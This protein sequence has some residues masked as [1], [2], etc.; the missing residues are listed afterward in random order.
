MSI[1][2]PRDFRT[3]GFFGSSRAKLN[4][5]MYSNVVQAAVQ[6]A[7]SGWR[8][9]NLGDTGYMHAVVKGAR[10]GAELIASDEETYE[11]LTQFVDYRPLLVDQSLDERLH[12]LRQMDAFIICPGGYGTLLE[13]SMLI[14]LFNRE[15]L[16]WAPIYLVGTGWRI[17][18]QVYNDYGFK[19]GYLSQDNAKYINFVD[20]P[21]EASVQLCR[22]K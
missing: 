20:Y 14:N 19:E 9:A 8:V 13:F 6:L 7:Q 11:R 5:F 21:L 17:P 22:I 16:D 18:I 15:E 12:L 1:I 4:T 3:V 2:I 10:H